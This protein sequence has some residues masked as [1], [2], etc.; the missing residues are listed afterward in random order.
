[1]AQDLLLAQTRIKGEEDIRQ[2]EIA[3]EKSLDEAEIA[4]NQAI[5]AARISADEAVEQAR[6][7]QRRTVEAERIAAEQ[8]IRA[9]EIA[10]EEELE[11]AEIERERKVEAARLQRRKAL[12]QLEIS[13]VQA[14][15]EAEIVSQEEIERA[16]VAS[17]RGLD[18]IRIGHE[19]ERRRL[20]VE[21][22]R[23]VEIIQ[24]E[25]AIAL[26]RKSLEESAARAEADAARA[27]AAEAEEKIQTV[28]ETE[29][30]NRRKSIDVLMAE[31][32][33]AEAKHIA[34][35][36]NVL[37]DP[38]RAS[39][40][41]R[42]LLE[43]VEGIVAASVKP[44]EKIQDIRI[45]QLDGVSGDAAARQGSPTDEVINSALRYRVQAP[46]IDNLLA[47]IGIEGGNL[48]KQGGL[49]REASDMQRVANE[50]AKQPRPKDGE[51]K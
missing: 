32:A 20:E 19:T 14:L 37:T 45:M 51:K 50:A 43:H 8:E 15:R 48:A 40:F 13:R 23:T 10:R 42:K 28:R 5:D 47:D 6:I 21:R 46:L 25:K 12:E 49:M 17:Q 16:R 38:A 2:R 9:R 44:L 7:A 22:E 24:M 27:R 1:M 34:E 41:R 3:R 30:A 36:E 11:A 26:Y 29:A 35:A 18:E 39:L 4:R 31:K 33:A